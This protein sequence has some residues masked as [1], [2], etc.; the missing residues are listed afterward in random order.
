MD[1]II[2]RIKKL[3]WKHV[4]SELNRNGYVLLP[5]LFSAKNCSYVISKYDMEDLFR[6]KV[7]MKRHNFGLGEYK[8]FD[9][10]LP[11]IIQIIRESIY[12]NLVPI[13][14]LW[15]QALKIE[16]RFPEK[17]I[18][19][20]KECCE[21]DQIKPTPL[22]LKYGVGGFN[23]LH[24]DLYGDVYF[25]FQS[26]IFLTDPDIDYTGGEFVITLQKPRVQPKVLVIK[27]KKGDMVIFA[28]KF[29]LTKGV[30][31][32]YRETVK[33]GVS[34]VHSG[35]RYTLGIIYHDAVS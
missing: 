29:K 22:I 15:M 14:N 17:L 23:T 5:R 4:A 32:Y 34:E 26:A 21:K 10:P 7:T 13:A 25:P 12:S 28:T 11:E 31:G 33:H 6:K 30:K 16:D 18:D 2:D 20:I 27:P 9:Y 24:Q 8:Y 1:N 19:L 3:D 35:N